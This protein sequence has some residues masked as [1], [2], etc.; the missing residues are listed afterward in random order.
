M[1]CK[2]AEADR[3]RL[4][5]R[6]EELEED[7]AETELLLERQRSRVVGA[8]KAWQEATGQKGVWPDLGELVEWMMACIALR[9]P[10]ESK[11]IEDLKTAEAHVQEL[12]EALQ[13]IADNLKHISEGGDGDCWCGGRCIPA[14]VNW[15]C[16]AIRAVM[17][18]AALA[19]NDSQEENN[20]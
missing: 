11:L 12:E 3:D 13:S 5:Q 7:A 19:R 2:Q 6:V 9:E 10:V 4:A 17:N 1:A 15:G 18:K 14:S 20:E 8:S 16:R